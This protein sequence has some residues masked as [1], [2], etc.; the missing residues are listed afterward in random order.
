[1]TLCSSKL[2][3]SSPSFSGV[4]VPSLPGRYLRLDPPYS[5]EKSPLQVQQLQPFLNTLSQFVANSN[6]NKRDVAVQCLEAVLPR[7]EVRRAVWANTSLVAG[8]AL[9]T[10][11]VPTLSDIFFSTLI[12]WLTS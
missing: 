9:L 6:L 1:M 10:R 5:S 7:P 11:R 3:R 4:Y 2:P 8:S 12:D